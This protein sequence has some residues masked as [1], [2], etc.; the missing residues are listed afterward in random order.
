MSYS[1]EVTNAALLKEHCVQVLCKYIK[2]RGYSPGETL[3]MFS[4]HGE[5]HAFYHGWPNHVQP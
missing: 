4:N 5:D 2:V 3:T 1:V